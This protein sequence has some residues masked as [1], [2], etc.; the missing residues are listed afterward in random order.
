MRCAQPGRS[1][2]QS[3]NGRPSRFP[4]PEAQGFGLKWRGFVKTVAKYNVARPLFW[5]P[6]NTAEWTL[7][8]AASA[9]RILICFLPYL[10]RYFAKNDHSA[11]S[12]PVITA[13]ILRKILISHPIQR[14]TT[15][16]GFG[17]PLADHYRFP[18]HCLR[19]AVSSWRY[20]NDSPEKNGSHVVCCPNHGRSLLGHHRVPSLIPIPVHIQS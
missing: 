18:K 2:R 17:I 20:A 19:T 13:L 8:D 7:D 12:I 15:H 16:A 10:T 4:V 1:L 14:V 5:P 11:R 3:G 9:A 6:V